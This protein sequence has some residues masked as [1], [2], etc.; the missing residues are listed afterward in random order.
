M[1]VF[2]DPPLEVCRSRDHAGLYEAADRGE[3]RQFPGVS[4]PYDKPADA[5]L[6]LDTSRLDV[7]AC[8]RAILA[9]LEAGRFIPAGG[10]SEA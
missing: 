9:W 5:D 1:E 7:D 3:I 6:V 8:V 2:L 10:T 4:A